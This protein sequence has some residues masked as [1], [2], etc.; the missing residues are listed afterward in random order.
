MRQGIINAILMLPISTV[1]VYNGVAWDNFQFW[2]VAGCVCG[3]IW[4][5]M[6]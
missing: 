1:L 2:L 6:E 5:S 3:I 4:N